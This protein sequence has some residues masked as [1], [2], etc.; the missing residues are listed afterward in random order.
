MRNLSLTKKHIDYMK[1]I[2]SILFLAALAL[3]ACENGS[4]ED[5]KPTITITSGDVLEVGAEGGEVE[6]TYKLENAKQGVEFTA[7]CNA[8]W[9]TNFTFGETIKFE[10]AA[11]DGAERET[12]VAFKY[13]VASMEITVKQAE[14]NAEPEPGYF[15]EGELV[16]AE[17]IPSSEEGLDDNYYLLTFMEKNHRFALAIGLMGP[18][19]QNILPAGKY[20]SA[21]E[22]ILT[23]LCAVIYG[24][25]EEDVITFKNGDITVAVE[26]ENYSLDIILWDKDNKEDAF[27]FTYEG[28]IANMNYSVMPEPQEFNPVKV[29]AYRADS[30]DLGNFELDLYIDETNYHSLDMQD[31][32]NPNDKVRLK[33]IINE[34]KRKIGA[35]TVDAV[36]ALADSLGY[37]AMKASLN[38]ATT[39]A[40]VFLTGSILPYFISVWRIAS[41]ERAQY[42]STIL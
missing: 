2:F 32:T 33:R 30:W 18:N 39:M 3:V 29:E 24:E 37:P 1:K 4:T 25:N 10:V 36:E 17:R 28:E 9:I 41:S 40:V 12:K 6:V 23:D 31:L 34:P 15:F 21:D 13:D 11:N 8:D 26:G 16:D 38:I 7:E 19:G 22:T 35:A 20:T 27:H 14:K 42:I 5:V